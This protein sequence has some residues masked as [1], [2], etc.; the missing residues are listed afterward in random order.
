MERATEHAKKTRMR[1]AAISALALGASTS[2]VVACLPDVSIVPDALEGGPAPGFRG[3]G[4]GVIATLDDGGDAGEW[5]DPGEAGAKGCTADCRI[6][7]DPDGGIDP[8]TRHCYF[9]IG[10]RT[11]YG[12]AVDECRRAGA[13]VV[14]IGST[15]E[16]T[17]V[18]GTFD[19]GAGYFVGLVYD[20]AVS[21][22]YA[23]AA[24]DEP[25]YPGFPFTGPCAGCFGAGVDPADANGGAIPVSPL[26]DGGAASPCVIARGGRWEAVPCIGEVAI[27]VVCEREP[28]GRRIEACS[29]GFCFTL[30]ATEG[31]KTYILDVASSSAEEAPLACAQYGGTPVIF[32]SREERE[33]LA[34]EIL[35]LFTPD[36]ELT[37]W[38]GASQD[39][40]AWVWDDGLP[41]ASTN[42]GT[43][44]P[45]P[46]GD[47]EP[48]GAPRAYMRIAAGAYDT[49]LAHADSS[50]RRPT[51]CQR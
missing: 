14:T 31:K 11:T 33:E 10:P 20:Q 26:V 7:C 2:I 23:S 48:A 17:F 3:C 19:A 28:V 13:H 30:A 51:L 37:Y 22:A 47:K 43:D 4:D 21:Q 34:H 24:P 16:A 40:G 42:A 8:K 36:P 50:D 25:A 45:P 18:D 38:I 1:I 29:G 44:R 12:D 5:C 49:Q 6:A 46:W 9:A 32:G 35:Q 27:D 39:G 41:V 15:D